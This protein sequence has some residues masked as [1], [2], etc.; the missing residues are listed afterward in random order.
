MHLLI[1]DF[2]FALTLS[3]CDTGWANTVFI[4]VIVPVDIARRG[5]NGICSA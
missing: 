3:A 1:S 5:N 2:S 4:V